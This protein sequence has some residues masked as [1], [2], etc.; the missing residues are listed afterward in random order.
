MKKS[1]TEQ[2]NLQPR[3]KSK[4]QFML[5]QSDEQ[6]KIIPQMHAHIMLTHLNI[7]DKVKAYCSKRDKTILKAVKQIHTQQAITPCN[8]HQISHD[9]RR[10]A[11][12]YLMLLK[13]K[14]TA[15]YE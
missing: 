5:T 8:R 10:K 1:Q 9:E 15:H 12:R 4:V 6:S 11:L 2:M 3:P 14:K 13:E 7:K